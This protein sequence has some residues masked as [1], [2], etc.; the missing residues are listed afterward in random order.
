MPR[1]SLRLLQQENSLPK[2]IGAQVVKKMMTN[3]LAMN[4]ATDLT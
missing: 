3:Q 1:L 4:Q 2:V